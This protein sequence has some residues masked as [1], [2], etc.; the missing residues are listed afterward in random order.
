MVAWRRLKSVDKWARA[1]P[2]SYE[3]LRPEGS[4]GTLIRQHM[5]RRDVP[6]WERPHRLGATP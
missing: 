5:G 3:E 1:M 6:G 2:L 4:D